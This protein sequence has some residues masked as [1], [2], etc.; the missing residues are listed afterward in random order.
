ME[1]ELSKKQL[2]F[3]L[4][5]DARINIADGAI[6]SG[7]TFVFNLRWLDYIVN[8]PRGILLMA[9]KTIRT[10]E[11]NVLK[12]ENGLFDLV[13]EGNYKYNGSTGELEIAGRKIICIGASDERSENK[14]RG[15]TLAGALC[16]EVT[17]FPKSFVE[18]LIGR[19]SVAGSQLFWNCNPDS[20]YHFIKQEYIDNPKMKHLVKHWRFLMYDNPY[21]V[22]TNPEYI[23]QAETTYTGVFYKRNVRGEWALAEGIVYDNFTD[24]CIVDDLPEEFDEIYVGVD[25]GVTHPATFIMIGVK[26]REVYVIK[27][28]YQSNRTNSELADEFINFIDGYSVDGITVDSAAASL[29]LEFN[30]RG[31]YTTDCNKDVIDGITLVTQLIGE[32]RLFVHKSCKNLI[33]E[34]YTYSWD[35]KK[36][37]SQGKDVVIKL[38][39]DCCDALRYACKTFLDFDNRAYV[40]DVSELG[41]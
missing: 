5:S 7:K 4:T 20:P 38:N 41:F 10:L 37:Q 33:K 24:K 15:M 17:L 3:L 28:F 31:I 6:R 35:D 12:A 30:K 14:I 1:P 39:D 16:D 9:G 18:Q 8:G 36:S 11:R 27:E 22:K 19:C 34:F 26:D 23:K 2:H 32:K 40:L 29:I 25:H 21:L 13:G